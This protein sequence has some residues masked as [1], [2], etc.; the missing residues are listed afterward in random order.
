MEEIWLNTLRL[1]T[2]SSAEYQ[3]LGL[4]CWPLHFY[5]NVPDFGLHV[6]STYLEIFVNLGLFGIIAFIVLLATM[7]KV[8]ADILYS[9]KK[10]PFYGLGIGIILAFVITLAL[11]FLESAPFCIPIVTDGVYH[12]VLSP[13]LWLFMGSLV[14]VRSLLKETTKS[15]SPTRG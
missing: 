6:H 7:A 3:G 10:H 4:G 2:G 5:E 11:G 8:S 1:M 9:D 12:F 13:V 15:C 14:M